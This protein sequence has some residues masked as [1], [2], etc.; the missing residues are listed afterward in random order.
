VKLYNLIPVDSYFDNWLFRYEDTAGFLRPRAMYADLLCPVC[1]KLDEIAAIKRGIDPAVTIKSRCD[2]IELTDGLIA[3]SGRATAAFQ[4]QGIK[5]LRFIQI[6]GGNHSVVWP[7][8]LVRTDLN[9][10]GFQFGPKCRACGRHREVCVGPLAQSL[11]IP[12]DPM[13]VFASEVW[14]EDLI[15]RVLW[16]FAQEPVINALAG[17]GLSGLEIN[18]VR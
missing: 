14:N 4:N 3:T 13:V 18:P 17:K 10:A 2:V 5:G 15:G 9:T 6:P 11:T 1:R 7:E 16:L 12:E 8:V